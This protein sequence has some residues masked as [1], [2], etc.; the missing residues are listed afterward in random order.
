LYVS[1]PGTFPELAATAVL[2]GAV[3]YAT[4]AELGWIEI[5]VEPVEAT[6]NSMVADTDPEA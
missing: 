3:R 4:P 1:V 6:W 2:V 5:R